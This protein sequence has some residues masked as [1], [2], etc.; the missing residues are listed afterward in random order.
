MTRME[1]LTDDPAFMADPYPAYARWRRSGPVRRTTTPDGTAVWLVTRYADVRA[2]LGDPRLSLDRTNSRGGY[3]GFR[4]PPALDRNLLNMDAPDH[5]RIRRLVSRAFTARRVEE[6]RPRIQAVTNRLLDAVASC[7]RVDLMAALAVPLPLTVIGELLGVPAG[8]REAFRGWTTTL[9]APDPG[10]PGQAGEA[11]GRMSG[12]LARLVA[13]KRAEPAD[14]LISAM[15]AARDEEDRLTEEEMTSLAFLIL[16][17]GYEATVHLVGNGILT[18][19][20]HPEWLA[21][22]RDDPALVAPVVE[23]VLRFVSPTPY[24]IRRFTV[25]D[26]TIGGV[27]VPAGDTVLL[28]LACAH[29]DETVFLGPENFAPGPRENSHLAFGYGAHYCLGAPL[30]R[31]E[32]Q[33]AIGTLVR[34]HPGVTAALPVEE[35]RW[36]PS[37]R[38]HGLLEL[39]VILSKAG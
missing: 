18:L 32:A 24:A 7:D 22:V 25:E 20:R 17:A 37:Y 26:V 10:R 12:L 38:S 3:G 21:A 13:D 4:L 30:A 15:I 9:I 31:A 6:M 8:D 19:L 1:A 14:D 28:S 39:P 27:T 5:T 23:E 11:V 16:W 29:H 33:I 35:L 34:R 2:A 36:Q